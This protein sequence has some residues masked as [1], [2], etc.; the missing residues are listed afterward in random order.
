MKLIKQLS[1]FF[2]ISVLLFSLIVPALAADTEKEEAE[3]ISISSIDEFLSFAEGCTLDS[4]SRGKTFVLKTD[5]S[6]AGTGFHP[7]QNFFGVF[8][9]DGHS[10]KGLSVTFE[11]SRQGLFRRLGEEGVIK[12]LHVSGIVIPGGSACISGGIVGENAGKIMGCSFLG[13]VNGAEQIGG[14]CGVNL[15]TGS[16]NSCKFSGST[17][18]QKEIGGICGSNS[19]MIVSCRNNGDVCT[20]AI[21]VRVVDEFDIASFD[22]SQLSSD[23]FVNVS[24]LGGISGSNTGTLSSCTNSGSVGYNYQGFNVGGIA[25]KNAGYIHKCKNT[26][27]VWGQQDV[28]GICGQLIPALETEITSDLVQQMQGQIDALNNAVNMT[29]ASFNSKVGA[30]IE[31]ANEMAGYAKTIGEEALKIYDSSDISIEDFD[32]DNPVINAPD[33]TVIEENITALYNSSAEMSALLGDTASTLSSGIE[34]IILQVDGIV[35]TLTS[36]VSAIKNRT[37]LSEDISIREA[38]QRN[39]GAISQCTNTGSVSADSNA[40]GIVGV[41]AVELD[42]DIA[43]KLNISDYFLSDAKTTFFAIVRDCENSSTIYVRDSCSGGIAGSMTLG[44]VTNS[45]SSGS[46]T[47]EQG[48]YAG[49]IAGLSE[50]TVQDCNSRS[51]LA[52]KSYV[53]GICGAGCNL[54]HCLSYTVIENE[55][56]YIGSV[57]GYADGE[58]IENIY[59]DNGIGAIDGASY[60]NMA[61][62]VTYEEMCAL[63]YVPASFLPIQV[64]FVAEGKTVKVV[65]VDFG[66]SI[67]DIPVIPDNEKGQYWKW[68]DFRTYNI[69]TGFTVRG[70][71][72]SPIPTLASEEA[73]PLFLVEG[74]FNEKQSL[75]VGDYSPDLSGIFTIESN[76][77]SGATLSVN[78][79]EGILTVR[80]KAE[81]GGRLYITDESGVLNSASYKADG[82]YI[83]FD[84]EN[85]A[86]LVYITGDIV[87]EFKT[88]YIIIGGAVLASVAALAV[89]IIMKHRKKK[90]SPGS[91]ASSEIQVNDQ[92]AH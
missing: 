52:G 67:D 61:E 79:Y 40:G 76:S 7:I 78:D 54:S 87:S 1:S 29:T 21:N 84:M 34:Y 20:E 16:I 68:D 23:D 50:G 38:Y 49:G 25:G 72:Y 66:G 35:S 69:F 14:I 47:A 80:M 42:F 2:L 8:D 9:G 65:D 13:T 73:E 45:T 17:E 86:S 70:K 63:D 15:P 81:D 6:L 10:I 64:K 77:I 58:L 83:V 60:V 24:N 36:S 19:G 41:S 89:V 51:T 82:S 88:S 39:T 37:E 90:N 3:I 59:V 92:S 43:D 18:G 75:S 5:L 28:G 46:I 48:S 11:G 62:P 26:A 12:D 22:V 57:A 85:G 74:Q 53:G 32:I 91:E 55:C 33:V 31:K 71:Y 44:A 4:Y 56:E 27:T 30:D